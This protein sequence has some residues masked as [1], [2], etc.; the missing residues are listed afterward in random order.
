MEREME[1]EGELG[2]EGKERRV[3]RHVGGIEG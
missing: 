1:R 3:E 2:S